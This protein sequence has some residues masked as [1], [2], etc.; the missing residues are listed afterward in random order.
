MGGGGGERR[1]WAQRRNPGSQ[2]SPPPFF[3]GVVFSALKG[4]L[5]GEHPF[6]L[7]PP[8]ASQAA[9]GRGEAL[10]WAWLR[11]RKTKIAEPERSGPGDTIVGARRC[12]TASS[13]PTGR[14]TRTGSTR[15]RRVLKSRG[16]AE[17]P[18]SP[19]ARR[20]RHARERQSGA[21]DRRSPGHR[22]SLRRGAAAQGRQGKRGRAHGANL[23]GPGP[24]GMGGATEAEPP[25]PAVQ[26]PELPRLA[27][28]SGPRTLRERSRTVNCP[29]SGPKE[30]RPVVS[31]LL[32]YFKSRAGSRFLSSCL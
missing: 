29:I 14:R 1:T 23:V 28:S 8:T 22:P 18:S 2:A 16:R 10:I 27:R 19:T 21:G 5:L 4:T 12:L 17:T 13:P 32:V 25:V 9:T 26:S 6:C 20:R 3:C 11:V 15:A 31:L 24:R 30:E 7:V